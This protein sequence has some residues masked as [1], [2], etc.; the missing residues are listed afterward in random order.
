[1]MTYT[2][3]SKSNIALLLAGFCVCIFIAFL[4]CMTAGFAADPVHDFKTLATVLLL[5]LAVLT[6]PIYGMMFRWSSLGSI[7]MWVVTLCYF[8]LSIIAGVLPHL[9]GI[10]LL[11]VIEALLFEAIKSGSR[12][13]ASD[14]GLNSKT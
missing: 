13:S 12:G 11:L 10:L 5:Y 3:Y 1:M 9:L 7:A 4:A 14:P 6:V 2:R 8:A